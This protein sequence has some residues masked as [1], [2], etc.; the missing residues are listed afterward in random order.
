MPTPAPTESFDYSLLLYHKRM[1]YNTLH[2][3]A[4]FHTLTFI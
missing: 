3:N 4:R 2:E 1:P